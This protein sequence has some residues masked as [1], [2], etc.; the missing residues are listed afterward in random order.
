MG[1][2]L[3]LCTGQRTGTA[4]A[5]SPVSPSPHVRRRSLCSHDAASAAAAA[6]SAL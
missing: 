4:A 3:L 2:L 5:A 6:A 1:T